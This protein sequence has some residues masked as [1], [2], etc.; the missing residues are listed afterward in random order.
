MTNGDRDLG[1]DRPISRRDFLNGVSVAVGASLIKPSDA[2]ADPVQAPSLGVD[3]GNYPPART[4]L[5]GSHPGSFEV[6]HSMRDGRTYDT[7]EDTGETYDL[8]VV[9]GGMSGLAAAYYFRKR[10][11]PTAR[12]LILDNHDDFG[13][14]A[15][16]NEFSVNGRLLLARGGTSYIERVAT[17]PVEGRELLDEI[18]INYKEPTYKLDRGFYASLGLRSGQ[19]FDKETFGADKLVL[20]PAG[21]GGFGGG[22]R[23]PSA[24][25]LAQTPLQPHVQKELLRLYN[26]KTDFYPGLSKAEKLQKLKKISYKD[27]LLNV[28]KVHP[29]V[30]AYYHPGGNNCPSL[31]IDTATAWFYLNHGGAGFG[32]LGVDLEADAGSELD[33]H[34]PVPDLPEQFHF[35]EGV[36]GVAR[37]IVRSLIP[38]ALPAKSMADCELTK[39]HYARLDSPSNAVRI[40]LSSTAVRV[41]NIGDPAHASEVEAIYV[42]DGKPYRVRAK[43]VVLACNH[44]VIP[45]MCPELPKGQKDALHLAVRATQMITNVAV[46]DWKAFEKMGLSSI[47]CPGASYP[48]YQTMSLNTPVSMGGYQ[49]PK[50]SSEP[51]VVGLGGG[52][53]GMERKSGMNARDMFR[54]ARAIMYQTPFETYERNIRTH[55][56]R[57]LGPGGFEPARDIAAITINRWPHGYAT[58]VNYLFDPEVPDDDLPFVKARKPFGRITIANSDAVGVCLTQ[59]AFDQA[60]RAVS[61]LDKRPMAYW[62]RA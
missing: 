29:D 13:G 6:A 15:R 54:A 61:E 49:P 5:R 4:G 50:S 1:M 41:R 35:P 55:M 2:S 34:P 10:T 38:D 20:N 42:R 39:L 58:G 25:F 9:G 46:R 7:G 28:V 43:G 21:Q 8:V 3:D 32:G 30:L 37:L 60:Y 12:I 52:M 56:A 27:Y 19:F 48:G 45:Y 36:G 24:E 47:S 59:A 11:V 31:T 23:G 22:G 44:A 57:L 62:N 14:H 40:R 33:E 17:F 26:E 53:G 51:I 18:G 16:R